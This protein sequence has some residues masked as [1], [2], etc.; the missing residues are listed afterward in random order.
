ML[1]IIIR[2]SGSKQMTDKPGIKHSTMYDSLKISALS[3]ASN[4][5]KEHLTY[6]YMPGE[7][8]FTKVQIRNAGHRKPSAVIQV[9]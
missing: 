2:N 8:S 7:T 4:M 3:H 9:N 5:A 1:H 6:R